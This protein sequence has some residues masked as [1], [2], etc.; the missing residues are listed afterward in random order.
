MIAGR[1]LLGAFTVHVTLAGDANAR[2]P[3]C[4]VGES[5]CVPKGGILVFASVRPN[6]FVSW[7]MFASHRRPLGR[8]RGRLKVWSETIDPGVPGFPGQARDDIYRGRSARFRGS[9]DADRVQGVATYPDGST[10]DFAMT[11]EFGLGGTTPNA[12]MCRDANGVVV[13]QGAVDLQLIRLRGCRPPTRS[14]R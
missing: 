14:A 9:A 6:E 10:C 8:L 5:E 11:L 1:L 2:C 13:A 4:T 12:F 7:T 3:P